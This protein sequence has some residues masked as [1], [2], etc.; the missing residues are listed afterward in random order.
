MKDKNLVQEL[1]ALKSKID[2]I[3][4]KDQAVRA[5]LQDLAQA[6]QHKLD[7]LKDE[8]KHDAVLSHLEEGVVA[9]KVKHPL[10]SAE[11]ERLIDMLKNM[12]I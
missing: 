1:E 9:F 12:G 5:K 2:N 8:E 6:I 11:L 10:I 4:E 7:D 3:Q